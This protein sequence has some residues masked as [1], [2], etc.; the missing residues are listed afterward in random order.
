[1]DVIKRTMLWV[2]T[3]GRG[4]IHRVAVA[5]NVKQH[6]CGTPASRQPS[7]GVLDR[8]RASRGTRVPPT[9]LLFSERSNF[10][11][12]RRSFRRR[13]Q[14]FLNLRPDP[15][16]HG[17]LRP[18]FSCNSFSACTT[19]YPRFTRVSEGNPFRRLLLGVKGLVGVNVVWHGEL[20][21]ELAVYR[22][23]QLNTAIR[24][25]LSQ[26]AKTSAPVFTIRRHPYRS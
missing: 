15:Q 14:H 10:A 6:G 13:R 12:C 8:E 22:T 17:S 24:P 2:R 16:G 1:M 5:L 19:R 3:L 7:G 23:L 4:R 11:G 9:R 21:S 18:S 20:Q 25:L 26:N